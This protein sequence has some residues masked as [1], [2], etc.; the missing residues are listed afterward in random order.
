MGLFKKLFGDSADENKSSNEQESGKKLWWVEDLELLFDG[1]KYAL[2]YTGDEKKR[3]SYIY[4]D[5]DLLNRH[6]A[7]LTQKQSDGSLRFGVVCTCR[8][9][10][11]TECEYTKV[12]FL[13]GD[14]A[15]LAIDE[16]G[17]EYAI[18]FWGKIYDLDVYKDRVINE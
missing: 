3:T 2:V 11:S 17:D 18:D 13:D 1:G 14:N 4:D 8:K 9:F 6:Q 15:V 7:R 16:D 12:S 10:F 5:V